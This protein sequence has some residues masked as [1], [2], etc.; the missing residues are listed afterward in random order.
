M[1]SSFVCEFSQF[2]D[3]SILLLG[4]HGNKYEEKLVVGVK[5]GGL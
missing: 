5:F 1:I 3:D 2:N 4:I